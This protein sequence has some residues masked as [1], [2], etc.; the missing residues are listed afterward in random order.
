VKAILLSVTV[1]TLSALSATDLPGRHQGSLA[2][3]VHTNAQVYFAD[4]RHVEA[5]HPLDARLS[6]TTA[7]QIF[8]M[9]TLCIYATQFQPPSATGYGWSLNVTP[10]DETGDSLKLR[11][12]WQRVREQSKSIDGPKG[13]AELTLKAGQWIPLDY[14]QAGPV[15]AGV[16][17]NAI[18]ML[19]RIGIPP[20]P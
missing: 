4:A 18:G 7:D 2:S 15:P 5:W 6:L 16:R 3:R 17:C 11:V 14:I 8:T 1:T 9:G 20:R 12:E 10:L 19:L 13:T